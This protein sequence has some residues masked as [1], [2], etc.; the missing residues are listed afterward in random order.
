MKLP[1]STGRSAVRPETME[2]LSTKI[3]R[4]YPE[5]IFERKGDAAVG[6]KG[7]KTL[8]SIMITPLTAQEENT[9]CRI[10]NEIAS[11]GIIP[12][13]GARNSITLVR[14]IASKMVPTESAIPYMVAHEIAGCGALSMILNNKEG[15][16][17]IMMDSPTGLLSVYHSVYGSCMTN[18]KFSSEDKFR[19]M[20]N[21]LIHKTNKEFG[22]ESPIIDAQTYD[23]S[24]VHAQT[25]PYSASG[26]VASIRLI[27]ENP[28]DLGR[29]MELGTITPEELAYIRTAVEAGC[30][31]VFAGAPASGKTTMLRTCAK[32]IPKNERII[33]IEEDL[34]ELSGFGGIFNSVQ[35]RGYEKHGKGSLG[36]QVVNAL[37]LRPD[38]L[39]IGEIR[40]AEANEV[41]FGANIGVQFMT[42][43]HSN[44]AVDVVTRLTT[45]PMAVE[46]ALISMLDVC[47]F[48]RELNGTR[49]VEEIVEYRWGQ[50]METSDMKK[51]DAIP[52]FKYGKPEKGAVIGSKALCRFADANVLGKKEALG[53]MTE[54]AV[55][56]TNISRREESSEEEHIQR[57]AGVIR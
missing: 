39:I 8:Y 56:M 3:I 10:K 16:E 55:D 36:G 4:E 46:P 52:I 21:R 49:M 48:M 24:R 6:E 33:T 31:I 27:N 20:I 2:S 51:L 37:R 34:G 7:G 5:Q 19:F 22:A 32:F 57:Y 41:L 38:R 40:G 9:A 23:G 17:E 42:T 11:S 28:I 30:N 29:L 18:L 1:W 12:D 35:L 15:I 26:G 50:N 44:S 47:V 45:K 14:D 53:R 43:L 13:I 25:S 54:M